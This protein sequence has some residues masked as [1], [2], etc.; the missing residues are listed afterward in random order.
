MNRICINNTC[1]EFTVYHFLFLF[2]L[3]LVCNYVLNLY[4]SSKSE[5]PKDK[6]GKLMEGLYNINYNIPDG[7]YPGQYLTR[8]TLV[9]K[10]PEQYDELNKSYDK[11]EF[12]KPQ[13]TSKIPK[14][15]QQIQDTLPKNLND[16]P[17]PSFI[18]T[19]KNSIYMMSSDS[20]PVSPIWENSKARRAGIYNSPKR[21][22]RKA[23]KKEKSSSSLDSSSIS[24]TPKRK[25][26]KKP[27]KKPTQKP[28]QKPTKKPTQ[29][30]TKKPTKK[31][32]RKSSSV[33]SSS[34][35]SSPAK[36]SKYKSKKVSKTV[37]KSVAKPK[38]LEKMDL[39]IYPTN[40]PPGMNGLRPL[41][42]E[43][44]NRTNRNMPID[45]VQL[46]N[47]GLVDYELIKQRDLGILANPLLPPEK[48][49]ERPTID[50]TL[51]L[52]R[53]KYIGLPTRGSYDTYQQLGYLVKTDDEDKVLKMFGRQKYPGSTQY[54]Y[55]AIKSTAADQYK[56]PLYDI[57]KQLYE[58]DTVNITK[59]FPG[60]YRF[61]EFK[62]E[63]LI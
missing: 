22:S 28:T 17:T 29:K 43:D 23:S 24:S 55:Y 58:G 53:N 7:I 54:E 60:T 19:E 4:L 8:S 30:P 3:V 12:T 25:P 6:K 9:T 56:V 62:Q 49:V 35:S 14:E 51:P 33:S 48:R 44:V 20:S 57:R 36:E 42:G 2:A 16:P 21:K 40:L 34:I 59:M 45:G 31:P 15:F 5:K 39:G 38:N 47:G 26:T 27:T 63:E 37:P 10:T 46:P 61:F 1:F 32:S 11:Y 41:V 18:P 13:I 52:I 50:M